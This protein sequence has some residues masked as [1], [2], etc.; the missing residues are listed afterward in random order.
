MTTPSVR[1]LFKAKPEAEIHFLTQRPSNQIYEFNPYVSKIIQYP[2]KESIRDVIG[3]IRQLRKERYTAVI[4]F[5]GLPKTALL[6]RLTGAKTRIGFDLRGRRRF[7]THALDTPEGVFYS[8]S[9]KLSLLRPLNVLSEESQIDFFVGEEDKKV[10]ESIL[11]QVGVDSGRPLVTVSPVS[12]RDYKVWP[13][14]NFAKVCDH[15]VKQYK[16][17]IL[18]LWGPGEYHFIEAVRK[19]MNETTLPDYDI[20]TIRETVALLQLADL[21]VG[22]DNG[23]MHFAISTG[24]PTLAVFGRPMSKNWIPTNSTRHL[25]AEF[26]PGC[27]EQ[28]TY[29]QCKMEC[30]HGVTADKV[31]KMID[32]LIASEL[33]DWTSE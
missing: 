6:S 18:F 4:D 24:M 10:A 17:Q 20:P 30:I 25:A 13:A 29:P 15:L 27:K 9:Q 32:G 14:A 33:P 1:A 7:Y 21:H 23:P 8:A 3:I 22:N 11:K 12:R 19:E 31:A 2:S 5:L 26:D 16:A 28:C